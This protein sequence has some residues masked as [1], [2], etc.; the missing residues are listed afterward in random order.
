MAGR[1]RWRA[2]VRI[3]ALPAH[4]ATRSS[5][6]Y[7]RDAGSSVAAVRIE[8][9]EASVE[10]RCRALKNDLAGLGEI[11]ELD[12]ARA[13]EQIGRYLEERKRLSSRS[14]GREPAQKLAQSAPDPCK[15]MHG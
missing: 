9:S 1:G 2:P 3:S 12:V 10:A 11:E 6:S 7:V 4:A 13:G 8:G 14:S 15:N 5:V